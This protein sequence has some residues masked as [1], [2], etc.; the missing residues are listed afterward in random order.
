MPVTL[1]LVRW[2]GGWEQI[3]WGGRE[4]C[5]GLGAE[6]SLAEVNRV[7]QAQLDTLRSPR[8]EV[9]AA[10]IPVGP[11]DTPWLGYRI[12]DYVTAPDWGETPAA[13][14]VLS[15]SGALDDN[16][17]LSFSVELQDRI[18]GERERTEQT[19]KKMTNGTLRGAS[20]VAT[21]V[22]AIG[23]R[24]VPPPPKWGCR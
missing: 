7:A 16:G 4:A 15:M 19:L 6:Q 5:L 9:A 21:P 13:Q 11:D 14:R 8:T 10:P 17:Q 18:L 23:K 1:L 22:G 24:N 2:I 12:G 20:K 3:G